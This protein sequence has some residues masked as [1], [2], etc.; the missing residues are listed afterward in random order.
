MN[1]NHDRVVWS[2][3]MFL[4]PQHFQQQERFFELYCRRRVALAHPDGIGFQRLIVDQDQLKSGKIYLRE[5]CGIFPDGTPFILDQDL[6]RNIEGVE[7]GASIY[8][9]LPLSRAGAIDTAP[10][11]NVARSVRYASFRRQTFDSNDEG[12]D[13][14]DLQLSR[15]NFSLMY[16]GESLDNFTFLRL[17]RIHEIRTDGELLLDRSFIP[18]CSDYKVSHYLE[19]QVQ[20]LQSLVGQRAEM[21]ASQVGVDVGQK[22]FQVMQITYMWLQALNR[23]G[24]QLKLINEQRN[25][26][27]EGLYQFLVVMAAELATFTR[28]RAPVFAAFEQNS[29]YSSFAPVI[30]S[31]MQCLRHASREKVFTLV[32]DKRLFERRRLLRARIEDRTLFSDSRFVLSVSSSL[33]RDRTAEVFPLSGKLCGHNRIAE[34]V[35][36]ALSG[37][38]LRLLATSP[39]EL[40]AKGNSCYFEVDNKDELWQEMIRTGDMLALHIDEQM[41]EDVQIDCYVIR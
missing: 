19:E 39:L 38:K 1:N 14:V 10:R 35:R 9:V 13:P 18:L 20:S 4:S 34:R 6:C 2:E 17:A 36:N 16:D 29:I 23:Y 3:G 15:L 5:A 40:K 33:G 22:S 28:S 27:A 8:L 24:A 31:L 7:A 37:V 25:L 26:S 11:E 41:P 32:W 21:L 30:A 12:N